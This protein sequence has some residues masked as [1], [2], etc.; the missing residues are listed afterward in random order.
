M[1]DLYLIYAVIAACAVVQSLFGVGILVFGT[2]MLLLLGFDF[3]TSL[4]YLIP[5][6]FAVSLLQ[7]FASDARKTSISI[8]L[9]TLCLPAIALGLWLTTVFHF[10]S[11]INSAIGVTLLGSAGLRLYAS[12]ENAKKIDLNHA[13]P[14]YHFVMGLLHGSTN[15]GGALLAILAASTKKEKETFRYTV[16]YYYLMFTIVQFGVLFLEFGP[17]TML[18]YNLLTGVFSALIYLTIGNPMFIKARVGSY[19]LALTTFMF[20]F[21]VLLIFKPY[22]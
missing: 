14:A 8:Y 6:S 18:S 10:T 4:S 3:V 17:Q 20:A 21:G 1:P 22:Y 12:R 16:A 19:Q 5:A 13:L 11:W 2:P 15:L 9:Y 7:V